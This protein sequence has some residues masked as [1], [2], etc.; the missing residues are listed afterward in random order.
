MPMSTIKANKLT[1]S[2]LDSCEG[3]IGIADKIWD[4]QDVNDALEG[5]QEEVKPEMQGYY[6]LVNYYSDAQ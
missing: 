4:G 2:G 3:F 6:K 5:I 1:E